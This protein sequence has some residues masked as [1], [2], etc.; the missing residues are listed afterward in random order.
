MARPF[1]FKPAGDELTISCAPVRL[2]SERVPHPRRVALCR[3]SARATKVRSRS[4]LVVPSRPRSRRAL[5]LCHGENQKPEERHLTTYRDDSGWMC[6]DSDASCK[7]M[8]LKVGKI[9]INVI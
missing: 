4:T 6:L 9:E 7:L 3:S 8:H 1:S 5:F 2:S